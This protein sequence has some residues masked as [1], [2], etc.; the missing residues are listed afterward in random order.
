MQILGLPFYSLIDPATPV[1]KKLMHLI[2]LLSI[3]LTLSQAQTRFIKG[4]DFREY[5]QTFYIPP[6]VH[7]KIDLVI[8]CFSLNLVWLAILV[9]GVNISRQTGSV[10][11]ILSQYCLYSSLISTII[12]LLLNAL[13]KKWVNAIV[14][15]SMLILGSATSAKSD[16]FLNM[17]ISLVLYAFCGLILWNS[18]PLPKKKRLFKINICLP[19]FSFVNALKRIFTLQTATYRENRKSFLLRLVLCSALSILTL[20]FFYCSEIK[21]T[22]LGLFFFLNTIQVYFIST[23]FNF[24]EKA[25]WDYALFYQVFP[26]SKFALYAREINFI[27][28]LL[29]LISSPLLIFCLISPGQNVS[30][31]LTATVLNPFTLIINRMLYAQSLRFCLLTSLISTVSM[32]FVQYIFLGACFAY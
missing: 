31:T 6:R 15:S 17:G 11:F 23:F 1:S 2:G 32:N 3:L 16:A 28:C 30:A 26:Y 25:K 21:E 9:A 8:L 4:G 20:N 10:L 19:Y 7:K 12:I 18:Q 14:L 13:Y 5:L 29:I 24:F 22:R 27:T